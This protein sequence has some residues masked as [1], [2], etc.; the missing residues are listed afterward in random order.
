ME[1]SH[2]Y[3]A[4]TILLLLAAIFVIVGAI[5]LSSAPPE[6]SEDPG[7]EG[8]ATFSAPTNIFES[9]QRNPEDAPSVIRQAQ[10]G[11]LTAEQQS[12]LQS[13]ISAWETRPGSSDARAARTAPQEIDPRT[14]EQIERDEI[15]DLF[16]DLIGT[17][18]TDSFA[19]SDGLGVTGDDLIWLGDY[20]GTQGAVS[21]PGDSQTQQNLRDYGNSLGSTLK[22]FNLAQGDQTNLLEKFIEDRTNTTA[23]KKLTDGYVKLSAEIAKIDKPD[24]VA[25]LHSGLIVSYKAVG[26]LLWDL[27]LAQNDEELVERMLIYN[28]S[29]EEVARHHV[30][31]VTLFKAH[32]IEFKSHEPGSIFNFSPPTQNSF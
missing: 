5:R 27:T 15:Q 10:G 2:I 20:T 13:I 17:K 29:S 11:T 24:Q 18:I 25:A 28:K 30:S 12:A 19:Q 1:R 32:G 22:A 6:R 14:P 21:D 3:I 16:N 4:G 31:L 23:L 9:L 8:Y 26:E 7:V